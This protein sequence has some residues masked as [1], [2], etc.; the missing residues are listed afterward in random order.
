MCRSSSKVYIDMDRPPAVN[1]GCVRFWFINFRRGVEQV[2]SVCLANAVLFWRQPAF[3]RL[4]SLALGRGR[5]EGSPGSC[6][7]AQL[8][9]LGLALCLLSFVLMAGAL[10][11]NK[12]RRFFSGPVKICLS[13]RRLLAHELAHVAQYERLGGFHEF[14]KQYL[15]ECISPGYPLG[16]LEQEAKQAESSLG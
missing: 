11:T 8:A 7:L 4:G 12:P 3:N 9:R 10:L 13:D 6:V 5:S 2:E 1:S 15:E 16:D 14:L